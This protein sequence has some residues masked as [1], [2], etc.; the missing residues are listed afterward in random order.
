MYPPPLFCRQQELISY[1][2]QI[3]W[4]VRY[5]SFCKTFEESKLFSLSYR[6]SVQVTRLDI[7]QNQCN[8]IVSV[9][10]I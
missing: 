1:K 8:R 9:Q 2:D 4:S 6:A 10:E 5:L 3:Y 7:K